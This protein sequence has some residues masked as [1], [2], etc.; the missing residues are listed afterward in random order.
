MEDIFNSIPDNSVLFIDSVQNFIDTNDV[1][2]VMS[3][4]LLMRKFSNKKNITICMIHHI[5]KNSGRSKGHTQLED[6]SDAVYFCCK[7]KKKSDG[8]Y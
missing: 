8:F 4:M 5:S 1:Q 7:Y 3:F 2:K 6:M